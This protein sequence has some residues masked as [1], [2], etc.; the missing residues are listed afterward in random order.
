VYLAATSA[1]A[2]IGIKSTDHNATIVALEHNYCNER[3]FLGRKH[4]EMIANAKFGRED[5][6]KMDEARRGRTSVQYTVLDR[7]GDLEQKEP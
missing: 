2:K 5:I 6:Q 1:L 7:Y 4:I 3:T